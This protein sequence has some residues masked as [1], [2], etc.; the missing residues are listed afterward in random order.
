MMN[1]FQGHTD[2]FKAL[3]TH[4]GV[5]NFDTM[6]GTT[7]ELWFDE[8]DHG[9]PWEN[10]DFSKYSPHRYAKSF[11][12]PNLVIHN[13]QDFRVPIGQG[14]DLFT[15]LQRLN[16]PSKFLYFPD[17]GHWVL[18]PKNSELWHQTIFDWLSQY[19]GK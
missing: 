10:S 4:C 16:V 5:Y 18:K 1:W 8:W 2:K 7:E 19:L 3:I 14:M 9:L 17:E 12:T 6:Y 11:K 13:E 15:T